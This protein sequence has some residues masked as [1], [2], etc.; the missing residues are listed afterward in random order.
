MQWG[1]SFSECCGCSRHSGHEPCSLNA[2]PLQHNTVVCFRSL[3][4]T[5][6]TL[7]THVWKV[8]TWELISGPPEHSGVWAS[9]QT[10][11]CDCIRCDNQRVLWL[12]QLI[13]SQVVV[14]RAVSIYHHSKRASS[15]ERTRLKHGLNKHY[16]NRWSGV[17]GSVHASKVRTPG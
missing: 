13:R 11:R 10:R 17:A 8:C 6:Y 9:L 16:T 2:P 12:V 15:P 14:C 5:F 3:T 4:L 7:F 1:C